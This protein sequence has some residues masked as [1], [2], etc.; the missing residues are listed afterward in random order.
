MPFVAEVPAHIPIPWGIDVGLGVAFVVVVVLLAEPIR[1]GVITRVRTT[2]RSP[3]WH[4]PLLAL[5][6]EVVIAVGAITLSIGGY[7]NRTVANVLWVFVGLGV[8]WA[9]WLAVREHRRPALQLKR[10]CLRL[11]EE[12]YEFVADLHEEETRLPDF[13]GDPNATGAQKIAGHRRMADEGTRRHH[14]AMVR[15]TQKYETRALALFDR[16]VARG[17]VDARLRFRIQHPTNEHGIKEVAQIL[18]TA[19][20]SLP[21]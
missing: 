17:V 8:V 3:A 7:H 18:G 15:Y 16:L 10:D 12:I 14:R 11:S 5:V 2:A 19:A 9:I 1:G 13:W 4:S 20:Q 6:V 21:D